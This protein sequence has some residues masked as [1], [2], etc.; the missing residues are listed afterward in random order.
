MDTMDNVQ[1]TEAYLAKINIGL[2]HVEMPLYKNMNQDVI[3]SDI[4]YKLI[5]K[6]S[7]MAR[8]RT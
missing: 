2:T 5:E 6:V 7:V 1:Q 8:K 4:N 3:G